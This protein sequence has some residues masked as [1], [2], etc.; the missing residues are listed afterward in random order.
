IQTVR[1]QV[2]PTEKLTAQVIY[3]YYALIERVTELAARDQNPRAVNIRNHHL[4]Q[5]FDLVTDWAP[6]SWLSFS[7]VV[8]TLDP[9][10]GVRQYVETDHGGWWLHFMLYAK[11]SF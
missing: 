5:G 3:N 9:G 6:T 8:A 11:V 1:L 7:G 2:H 10:A 4:G